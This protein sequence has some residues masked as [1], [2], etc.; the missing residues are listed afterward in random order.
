[1]PADTQST[2]QT[3]DADRETLFKLFQ[4]IAAYGHR[5][6]TDKKRFLL[7]EYAESLSTVDD[8]SFQRPDARK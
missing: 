4:A 7:P 2:N 1:M 3:E 8:A 5:I 6:R